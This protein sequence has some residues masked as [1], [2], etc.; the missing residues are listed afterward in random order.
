MRSRFRFRLRSWLRGIINPPVQARMS[1]SGQT[2]L[3]TDGLTAFVPR[4]FVVGHGEM[5][6]AGDE[7]AA[8]AMG[9]NIRRIGVRT[10]GTYG[11]GFQENGESGTGPSYLDPDYLAMTETQINAT[12]AEGMKVLLFCDSN[13]G[14]GLTGDAACT[15]SGSADQNFWTANGATKRAQHISRGVFLASHFYGK[16]DFMEP[17]VE[18]QATG[19]N[20]AALWAFYEEYMTAVLAV[21]PDMLFV[22][23]AYPSYESNS[24]NNAFNP[25]WADSGSPFYQKVI[26]TG[27]FLNN[28]AM[29]PTNRVDRRNKVVTARN[30]HSCPALIQ[31][32]GTNTSDDPDDTNLETL[33]DLFDEA[34]GGPIGWTYWEEHSLFPG[35]YGIT[36][37][38]DTNNNSS[39]RV[40]KP[41]RQTTLQAYMSGIP[42]FLSDPEITAT[43][44]EGQVVEFTNGRA[45]GRATITVTAEVF[46]DGVG[47]GTDTYTIQ[48][49][50]VGLPITVRNT[51]TNS[52]GNSTADS[53]ALD[54]VEAE[55]ETWGTAGLLG[56]NTPL[57]Y[58]YNPTRP[59]RNLTHQVRFI[60]NFTNNALPPLKSNGYPTS[61]QD[62]YAIFAEDGLSG[63]GGTF[64]FSV[65]G[66]NVPTYVSTGTP[67]ISY[68][69]GT[70]K[71]S[72]TITGVSGS[73]NLVLG[74][75][76]I[77][78]DFADM[79]MMC[80]GYS[81][82]DPLLFRTEWTDHV[83]RT[84]VLR[85]MD[86]QKTNVTT[87]VTWTGSRAA[88]TGHVLNFPH[89]VS[90]AMAMANA[91]G[92]E[93]WLCISPGADD[94]YISNFVAA[95]LADLPVG[96]NATIELANETFNTVVG[97]AG[98]PTL[99]NGSLVAAQAYNG[100]NSIV[101]SA[102]RIVSISRSGGNT[103]TIRVNSAH[104]GSAGATIYQSVDP[105]FCAAGNY[106]LT[107]VGDGQDLVFTSTGSNGSGT[108]RTWDLLSYVYVN[109]ANTLTAP[110]T[111][112]GSTNLAPTP[113][114]VKAHFEIQRCK[115]IRDAVV[116]Q[117][118]GDRI[119]VVRG[120][121]VDYHPDEQ[122][123][124]ARAQAQY[125]NLNW[126]NTNNGGLTTNIYM[127]PATPADMVDADAVFAQYE[128]SRT[129]RK[130]ALL[131]FV[132]FGRRFD[133]FQ[134]PGN[135]KIYET[136]QHAGVVPNSTVGAAVQVANRDDA[137]MPTLLT[138]LY[139]DMRNRGVGQACFF[140]SGTSTDY[141]VA[142]TDSGS[143]W[144]LREG[145]LAASPAQVK[146]TWFGQQTGVDATPQP[147]D[148]R[149]W[150]AIVLKD[151]L[152]VTA[153][154]FLGGSG[155]YNNMY[156]II[157]PAAKF[158]DPYVLICA[159]TTGNH[160]IA[161]DACG[162]FTPGDTIAMEVDGVE[163]DSATVTQLDYN[164]EANVPAEQL[165]AT[166]NL[167][168]GLHWV[169]I[170][171][172][173]TRGMYTALYRLRCST[174]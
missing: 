161:L 105:S 115:A 68:N 80:P 79:Q 23:G 107:G 121:L 69:A 169:R 62:F 31:Q 94:D 157:E 9:A 158:P 125:T 88:G 150:G 98:F 166:V 99:L 87:D 19:S 119:A 130:D 156:Y 153:G 93:P 17:I 3:D 51:A 78:A 118:A 163:V 75:T 123:G 36:Y 143:A 148:T 134:T 170:K 59:F 2:I 65:T 127:T 90:T 76:N 86:Q 16:I 142:P 73:A 22:V 108:V 52:I 45:I 131:R 18:P 26:I 58:S 173:Q 137:R 147:V 74:F 102:R 149:T 124:L 172:D 154:A 133:L 138:N 67:S 95:V 53:V 8:S 37:L 13:C 41:H 122:Y 132:N 61:G 30:N 92:A 84:K 171:L 20:Q 136:G 144:G 33:F 34:S 146:D 48:A 111:T 139:A 113:E 135:L 70:N 64:Q 112:Y 5:R 81:L 106:V 32:V 165:S 100:N 129:L 44:T 140:T 174:P 29:H 89:S 38:T 35:S 14:Q 11:Q 116:A 97:F 109:T 117:G 72:G 167:T 66:N 77:S 82:D 12:V 24:I 164:T 27:N 49:E 114:Q 159:P 42:A 46:V 110:L 39:A 6:R 101:N 85:L 43:P 25:A 168:Q 55:A 56:I 21:D 141:S 120:V 128:A 145:V 152:D 160:V 40:A 151:V 28:L 96:K 91:A 50:D 126:F 162:W 71:T 104:G 83:G 47:T 103:V 155:A 15:I 57:P 1:I 63:N 4:G 60:D 54:A 10:W 7:A